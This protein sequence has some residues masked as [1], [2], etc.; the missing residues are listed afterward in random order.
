M[1]NDLIIC[2]SDDLCYVMAMNE[3]LSHESNVTL[4]SAIEAHQTGSGYSFAL[5]VIC[6]LIALMH[7]R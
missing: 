4:L 3:S 2:A 5:Y 6:P 1:T 7:D